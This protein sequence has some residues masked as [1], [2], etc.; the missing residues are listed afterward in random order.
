[1]VQPSAY[2][3]R[4]R[5]GQ[6]YCALPIPL[7][8]ATFQKH[9][10]KDSRVFIPQYGTNGI[11]AAF[12]PSSRLEKISEQLSRRGGQVK[13]LLATVALRNSIIWASLL[14]PF[15][16][17]ILFLSLSRQ[18]SMFSAVSTAVTVAAAYW[19]VLRLLWGYLASLDSGISLLP[20]LTAFV[21]LSGGLVVAGGVVR[22]RGVILHH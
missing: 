1:M 15:I 6:I 17:S 7:P 16:S 21:I 4:Q 2:S 10:F 11:F 20:W 8:D 5:A 12:V 22:G 13:P 3:C 14:V 19:A 18:S 9:P